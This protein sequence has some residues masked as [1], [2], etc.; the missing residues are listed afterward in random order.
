MSPAAG[1]TSGSFIVALALV[2]GRVSPDVAAFAAA[3]RFYAFVVSGAVNGVVL[4]GAAV[5][6]LRTGVFPLWLGWMAAI[7]GL[8]A[9]TGCAAIVEN[10]PA[11]V[12]TAISDLAWVAYFL[13]IVMVS[14]ALI[15]AREIAST[16]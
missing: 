3:A 8:A 9:I 4:M 13:W 11:G 14:V 15:R 2:G 12:F 7:V 5:L 6:I 1:T 16:P 10:N